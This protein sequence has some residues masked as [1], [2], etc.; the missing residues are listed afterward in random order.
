MKTIIITTMLALLSGCASMANGSR[1]TVS[2]ITSEPAQCTASNDRGEWSGTGAVKVKRSGEPLA[3]QCISA[4]NTGTATAAS[5]FQTRYLVQN[6]ILDFC[7]PS[8]FI[9]GAN[10]AWYEY[11]STIHVRMQ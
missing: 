9:D 11:P 4:R 3:V 6:I 5:D 2:I 7:I 1:Q 8:C 10:R